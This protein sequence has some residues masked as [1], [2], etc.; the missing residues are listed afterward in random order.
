MKVRNVP[1]TSN[2][3][4]KCVSWIDHWHKF[5]PGAATICKAKGCSRSDI[6]GAHVKKC[7]SPDN[8][9]YIVPFCK[10]HNKQ[11]GCIEINDFVSLA[12]ANQN[13]TCRQFGISKISLDFQVSRCT[14]NWGMC[15]NLQITSEIDSIP[16]AISIQLIYSMSFAFCFGRI[17]FS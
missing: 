5:S 3:S 8:S 12:P 17:T 1:G 11:E 10:F 15:A 14:K 9:E 16:T 4:C 2:R 13:F 7:N 6:V